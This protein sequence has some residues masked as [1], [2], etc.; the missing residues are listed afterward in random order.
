MLALYNLNNYVTWP[1]KINPNILLACFVGNDQIQTAN[2]DNYIDSNPSIPC[3]PIL[4]DMLY[5]K[6]LVAHAKEDEHFMGPY[7]RAMGDLDIMYQIPDDFTAELTTNGR[8]KEVLSP[9]TMPDC[10]KLLNI[11]RRETKYLR[12]FVTDNL[13]YHPSVVCF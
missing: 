9:C 10:R 3:Y 1:N 4:A 5:C 6:G 7:L 13:G 2:A 8:A 11:S 12:K